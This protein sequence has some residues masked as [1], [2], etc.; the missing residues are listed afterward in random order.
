MRILILNYYSR[1]S[2]AVVN[3]LNQNYELFGGA[4]ENNFFFSPDKI[5]KSHR[6]K[7]VFRHPN[8]KKDINLFK[9]KIIRL[10]QDY[11]INAIIPTGTTITN[12]ISQVKDDIIKE[13]DAK[14]PVEDYSK[15]ILLADKWNCYGICQKIGI[16][17]PKTTLITSKENISEVISKYKFPVIAKPRLSS[18]SKG[19]KIFHH[20][21]E[22]SN[23]F[24][25][26]KG[27]SLLDNIIQEFIKGELHDV[28]GISK[29]GENISVITQQ[30]IMSL[31]DFGGGGIINK[32][33]YNEEL[34]NYFKS[35]SSHLKWNGI[36]II[37]FIKGTDDNFYLLECNPKIW[38]T[39]YLTVKAGINIP[40]ILV[41][42][43]VIEKPIEKN[44][45]YEVNFLYKWIFPEC[46]FHWFTKPISNIFKRILN[47]FKR[48]GL[49]RIENN[50]KWA[51]LR[52]LIGIV[53]NKSMV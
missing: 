26:D 15:L 10:C 23:Y 43:F 36:L 31:Y 16:P 52:H 27:L 1:N 22:L 12:C 30:R 19:I 35:I 11:K 42:T 14:I 17:A 34:I 25:S 40:Q 33:T 6:I 39:T 38:G 41:D 28:A 2:L 45:T 3:S 4:T 7:K 9:E 44:N 5:F 50:L 8:P 18:A 47:T 24:N 48:H 20:S 51:D 21:E 29:N 32:T 13:T 37:D 53:I 46:I 49:S